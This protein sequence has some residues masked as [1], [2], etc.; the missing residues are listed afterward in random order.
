MHTPDNNFWPIFRNT[1]GA[2]SASEALALYNVCLSVPQGQ[3]MELGSY[4][5]KSASVA[6]IALKDG[7]FYLVDPLF[8]DDNFCREA[9]GDKMFRI[10]MIL[11]GNES[12]DEIPKHD[13]YAYVMVDSSTH[14]DGLPMQEVRL[15]EDRMV[16]GGIIAFHDFKS[17]FVEVEGAYNYLL[18]TGKYDE[19]KIDWDEIIAYVKENDLETGNSSWH[20]NEI[21][22]PCFVGAVKRK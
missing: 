15:L 20:H 11:V 21:D 10:N 1:E 4:K 9:M 8:R 22:F 6:A 7:D 19:I 2:F 3:Y 12:L 16:S 17:Q 14:Q 13:K 5:L 18:S